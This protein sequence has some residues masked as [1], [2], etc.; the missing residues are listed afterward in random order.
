M[1]EGGLVKAVVL[2]GK[3]QIAIRELPE[4]AT[5]QKALVQVERAGLCGTDLKILSGAIPTRP[6]LIL[7]HEVI[8]RVVRPGPHN[9]VPVGTRVLLDPGIACGHC[10]ECRGDRGYL[11]PNGALMGRDTNGGFAEFLAASE[12]QLH[13]L[14]A[15]I[16]PNAEAVLQVLATCVHA[17]SRIQVFP[18]QPAAVIGLGVSGL[19]HAQLLRLRGAYPII[20]ITRSAVKREKARHLGVHHTFTPQEATG[21]VREFT[22][23]RGVDIVVESVGTAD[24]L[25]QCSALAAPG[26]SVLVF[27][28]TSPTADAV[29]TYEWYYKE[30]DVVNSRAARSRDYDRAIELAAAGMV[31]LAPIVTS[32]YPLDEAVKAFAACGQPTELKVMLN[33]A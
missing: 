13:A 3:N 15:G 25:R 23:G 20:G 2:E 21:A 30:L 1:H 16:D 6:P 17:Q 33:V 28:T 32:T 8:G 12:D 27:G 19:L 10:T 11:C 29:P 9:L 5:Q 14:P 26:G 18:G 7:G 4:P 31:E 24:T 22:G